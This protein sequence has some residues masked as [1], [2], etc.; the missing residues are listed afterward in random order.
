MKQIEVGTNF[1][2][3]TTPYGN[4][5]VN[6]VNCVLLLLFLLVLWK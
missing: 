3:Q 4:W 6:Y 5:V 2:T 1:N